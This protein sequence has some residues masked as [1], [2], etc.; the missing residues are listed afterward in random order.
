[1]TTRVDPVREVMLDA[2]CM[3]VMT[4]HGRQ[5]R[6]WEEVAAGCQAIPMENWPI[7]GPRSALWVVRHISDA[8]RGGPDFK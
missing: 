7:E 2:R 4:P 1:M 3:E 6:F 8:G 5:E